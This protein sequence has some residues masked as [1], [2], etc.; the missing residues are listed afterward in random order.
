MKILFIQTN[1]P[2]FLEE[3]HK[4]IGNKERNYMEFKKLWANELF[5]SSDFY[6]KNL[7]SLGWV[8]DE[9]IANDWR[10]QSAWAKEH[11]TLLKL[12]NSNNLNLSWFSKYIPARIKNALGLNNDLKRILFAQIKLGNPD[13][14]YIHDVTYLTIKE[15][16]EL[17]KYTKLVVGQIAYP[18]PLN[19]NILKSYDLL[20][21]SLPNFVKDFKKMGIKT[22]YLR[23]C[24]EETILKKV[25][26]QK[27]IYDIT[28]IGGLSPHHSKGNKILDK[29]CKQ[30]KVNIWGYGRHGVRSAWGKKM[31]DIFS[32]SKIV[33]NRH[34]NISGVYANNMRMFEST[35]MGA[36]LLTDAKKN[37][38]EFFDVGKEV[39]TYKSV[40]DLIN[41]I[42]YYLKN[43]KERIMI[44]KAGQ[45]KTLK[46]H[47]YKNRMIELDKILK[48][49][50]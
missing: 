13:V 42:K 2:N 1:Y 23:W 36:L 35:G 27:R 41:K 20:I 7:K 15:I 45:K 9:I 11:P 47:T 38:H 32:K 37:M 46:I 3:F 34:I 49:Y 14:I 5:G 33:I 40:Q 30:I 29:V 4:R 24:F 50:V 48:K 25:K 16:N 10:I 22:E 26:Q 19:Q 44:A 43:D 28:Y 21:S 31:Y 18:K 17:K 12:R 6:L 8:G 39:V